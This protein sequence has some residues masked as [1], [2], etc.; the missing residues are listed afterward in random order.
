MKHPV[1]GTSHERI[2]LSHLAF[3]QGKIPAMVGDTTVA[4]D[5]NAGEIDHLA[6]V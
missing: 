5:A 4:P 3:G 1:G 6:P 2:Y